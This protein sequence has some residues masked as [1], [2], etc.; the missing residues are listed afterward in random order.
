MERVHGGP[1]KTHWT[2]TWSRVTEKGLVHIISTKKKR[3]ALVYLTN[4]FILGPAVSPGF[5]PVTLK[6]SSTC[7]VGSICILNHP[8]YASICIQ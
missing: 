4:I 8:G 1:Q 6:V 7:H 5:S 2:V 3:I